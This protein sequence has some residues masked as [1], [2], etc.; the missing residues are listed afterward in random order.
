MI[1]LLLALALLGLWITWRQRP[2]HRHEDQ[3]RAAARRY[4]VDATL[5]RAVVWQESRFDPEAVG[6][7]GEIGLMQVTDPAAQEWAEAEGVY[8]VAEACLFD[9]MTNVLAGTWYLRKLLRRYARTE[10]PLVYALAEYNAGRANVLRWAEGPA[11]TNGAAFLHRITFPG[12]SNYVRSVCLRRQF[13][14]GKSPVRTR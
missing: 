7:A 11:A 5:I 6:K 10:H 8:P 4:G 9:P 12:T 2:Q 13:Y 3:I 14:R 1:V